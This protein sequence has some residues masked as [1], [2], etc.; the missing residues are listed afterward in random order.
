MEIDKRQIINLISSKFQ[1]VFGGAV[2]CSEIFEVP[3]INGFRPDMLIN[4]EINNKSLKI[5]IEYKA[6]SRPSHL[7]PVIYR[8][9]KYSESFK[10]NSM[11]IAP[12]I[13]KRS[14]EVC[15]SEGIN[16]LDFDGNIYFSYRNIYINV[17]TI[18]R[19]NLE[20]REF[21]DLFSPVASRIVR[22]LLENPDQE[23]WYI[24]QLSEEANVSLGYTSE[25]VNKLYEEDYIMKKKG[26]GIK[27]EVKT[28]LL[29]RWSEA[30]SLNNTFEKNKILPF[31]TF[32][33]DLSEISEAVIKAKAELNLNAA[34]TRLAASSVLAPYVRDFIHFDLYIEGSIEK[35][36]HLLDLRETEK[37]ANLFIIKPYDK[38]VFYNNS[39]IQGVPVVG[40][41]QLY[42]DL[43]SYP[44]RGTEQA[45]KIRE[46]IIGF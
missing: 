6:I 23:W 22:V 21:K 31:Y 20:K 35:W 28:Q 43:W 5:I 13:S 1:E 3:E 17:R 26:L 41:I 12:Y 33:K 19:K 34:F 37:G 18:Q 27:L 25:V 44:K 24:K 9:K 4:T 46:K 2:K 32:S 36:K 8:L 15:R 45:E 40:T 10:G 38:G 7:L 42:V 16:Y 11:I 29:D 14:A 30:Y 39:V